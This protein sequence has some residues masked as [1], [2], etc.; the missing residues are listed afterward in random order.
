[1]VRIVSTAALGGISFTDG[2]EAD[3]IVYD[4]LYRTSSSRSLSD[5]SSSLPEVLAPP[6]ERCNTGAI[7]K[8]GT[9][10]W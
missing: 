10:E 6:A 5:S 7:I 8:K 9:F 2:D 4:E 1:M 3:G